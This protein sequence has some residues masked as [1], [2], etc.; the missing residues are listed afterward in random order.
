MQPYPTAQNYGFNYP[1]YQSYQQGY[2]G[3]YFGNSF[4]Q[5]QA[6]NQE[7]NIQT[8]LN[9][10][11]ID[12]ISNVTANEV[13]MNGSPSVFIKNDFSEIYLKQWQSDGT[14]KTMRFMPIQDDSKSK[15][16]GN[17]SEHEKTVYATFNEATDRILNHID[18][19]FA[20][21]RGEIN[22]SNADYSNDDKQKSKRTKK[23]DVSECHADD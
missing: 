3:P 2:T 14:I 4:H 22:E 18:S 10:R 6:Q 19:K 12:D 20:E 8:S 13:S 7:A 5:M 21:L 23:S 15:G 1:Q 16:S 9:G 11:I 17:A